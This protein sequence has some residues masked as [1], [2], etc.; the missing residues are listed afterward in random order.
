MPHLRVLAGPSPSSLVPI[1]VNTGQPHTISSDLFDGQVVVHIKGLDDESTNDDGYFTRPD[2]QGVTWSIQVQGHFLREYSADDILFGN[3]FDR[4]LKLPWGTSA[5]L[6]FMNYMD[7][8]LTHDLQST[9]KPWA[10]SPLISTMP[11]FAHQRILHGELLPP[12][13]SEE[14]LVDDVSQLY[15]A[16]PAA[17]STLSP[18]T[19]SPSRFRDSSS[20]PRDTNGLGSGS[21]SI[22]RSLSPS[23][24]SD[25]SG[26]SNAS[27][28]KHH[29]IQ[30][31]LKSLETV[32]QRRAYFTSPEKR[33]Q[34]AF[35]PSDLI[36]T[37]FCHGFLS[38]A[39]QSGG[40]QLDLPGGLSFDLGRYWDGQP[41]RFVCCERKEDGE[42]GSGEPWG[43]PFWCVA[44]EMANE[45][46]EDEEG[47]DSET[48]ETSD[49]D[50]D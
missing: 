44:I 30:D 19:S 37:D 26:T 4:P 41:V 2:R 34:V 43:R 24:G 17:G 12:F 38:F 36:T 40:P 28:T 25:R 22:R 15:L 27:S 10:L 35:G 46:D 23:A 1:S 14:S 33:R 48:S 47:G 42:A 32:A 11:Y 9:T 21:G 13:P 7:P 49:S 29:S 18:G 39:G 3:T 16:V 50:L 5:V 31:E 20:S 45:E 6:R 8:T